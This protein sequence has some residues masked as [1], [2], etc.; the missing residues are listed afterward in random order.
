MST[1]LSASEAWANNGDENTRTR[2]PMASPT[3]FT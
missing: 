3:E 2:P 1:P